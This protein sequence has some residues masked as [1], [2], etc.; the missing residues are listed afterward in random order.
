MGMM[1]KF[2]R[3]RAEKKARKAAA[4]GGYRF[5][6]GGLE[7]DVSKMTSG[8]EKLVRM[9]LD[10]QVAK[11]LEK[12]GDLAHP[13]S[14]ERPEIHFVSPKLDGK[15][16]QMRLVT[17]SQ[18]LRDH[19]TSKGFPVHGELVGAEPAAEADVAVTEAA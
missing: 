12:S 9:S 18:E 1:D 16:I 3:D 17:D 8:P 10:R 7:M 14:G 5:F 15:G 4:R 6:V 11:F 2:K 19:L 13:V